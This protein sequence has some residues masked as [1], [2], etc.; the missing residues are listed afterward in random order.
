M[1]ANFMRRALSRLIRNSIQFFRINLYRLLSNNLPQMNRARF[2]QPVLLTGRGAIKLGKC[3]LGV[4]PSPYFF[5]GDIHVEARSESAS[6]VIEDGVWIN[7]SACIIADRSEIV[8]E[9]NTLIGPNLTIYD[10]DF[11]GVDPKK[12]MSSDY[13][14]GPVRIGENVFVGASVTILKGVTIG[15]NSIIGSGS[16][17][18]KSIPPDVIASGVPA[19]VIRTIDDSNGEH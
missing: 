9:K 3:N 15:K 16:I 4:W 5:S 10:S 19:K 11:H 12:R 7:N 2:R 6:V 18:S 14:T 17:V 1:F 13:E 8:I